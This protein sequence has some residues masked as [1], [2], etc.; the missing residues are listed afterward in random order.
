[1]Y[2][3]TGW[4]AV[5]IQ[6][7]ITSED[8]LMSTPREL[9]EKDI[10]QAFTFERKDYSNQGRVGH[11]PSIDL[12][13]YTLKFKDPAFRIQRSTEHLESNGGLYTGP[14]TDSY[15]FQNRFTSGMILDDIEPEHHSYLHYAL[16]VGPA[17]T[18]NLF[19]QSVTFNSTPGQMNALRINRRHR[20][21]PKRASRATFWKLF[22]QNGTEYRVKFIPAGNGN[23]ISVARYNR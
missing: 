8:D 3:T 15:F 10:F 22:D 1:M 19:G 4:R 7:H 21:A 5:I 23:I 6:P 17:V 18:H 16:P 9:F 13:L 11:N 14:V 2:L 12:D 20:I